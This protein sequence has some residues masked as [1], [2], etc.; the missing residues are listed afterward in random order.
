[1]CA[2]AR[3]IEKHSARRAVR[4]LGWRFGL[5]KKAADRSFVGER[6]IA[7][8]EA[9]CAFHPRIE[10]YYAANDGARPLTRKPL[11]GLHPLSKQPLKAIVN[12]TTCSN[13]F[14]RQPCKDLRH[15]LE[16]RRRNRSASY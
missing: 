5:P 4:Y 13:L 16:H 9:T 3:D 14:E 6:S 11:T 15:S 7:Q 12:P 2:N 1:M 10:E 8:D